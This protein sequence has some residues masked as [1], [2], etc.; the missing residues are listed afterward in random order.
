MKINFT[1]DHMQRLL[2]LA[3]EAL[4]D[5][6]TAMFATIYLILNK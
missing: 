1:K 4:F 6:T 5:R 3:S 2:D